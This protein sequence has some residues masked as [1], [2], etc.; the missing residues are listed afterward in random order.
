MKF[1]N[2]SHLVTVEKCLELHEMGIAVT[3]DEGKHVT[4]SNE[5]MD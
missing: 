5:R 4:F 3:V 1:E 2:S